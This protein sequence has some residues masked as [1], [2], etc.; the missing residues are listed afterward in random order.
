MPVNNYSGNVSSI[1]FY[2]SIVSIA[3]NR[4]RCF[5]NSTISNNGI[6]I[7]AQDF[8]YSETLLGDVVQLI[9]K[10]PGIRRYLNNKKHNKLLAHIISGVKFLAIKYKFLRLGKY[11]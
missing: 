4:G 6:D 1:T 8:R 10:S 7:N 2:E 11:F 3:V 5:N 9:N